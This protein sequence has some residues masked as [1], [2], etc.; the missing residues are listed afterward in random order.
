MANKDEDFVKLRRYMDGSE[1]F[2]EGH[3]IKKVRTRSRVIP[4]WTLNDKEVQK[5]L[6]RAFPDLRRHP[7]HIVRAGRWIRVIHL[8][9]R[10]QLPNSH[11]AKE[12]NITVNNL[13]TLLKAIRRVAAGRRADNTAPHGRE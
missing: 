13:K 3:Q 5:V 12:L 11:V 4:A 7:R 6:L 8:Y 2:M 1:G 9:Y 10:M